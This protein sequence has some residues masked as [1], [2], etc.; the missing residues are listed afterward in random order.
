MKSF[1]FNIDTLGIGQCNLRCPSCP[2]GNSDIKNPTGLMKP[3][4][5]QQILAKATQELHVTGVGLFSWTEP[6]LH[7]QLPELV[8][9]INSFN[10]P[11]FLSS[12]LNIKKD[13][14]LI[15]EA[16]PSSFRISTSGFNQP[17]YSQ[18]HRGGT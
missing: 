17:I 15:L 8:K 5:L 13:F 6:L 1:F 7:P 3:E 11:S 2:V 10:I 12:N 14:E 4:L 18:F 16:N 9:I